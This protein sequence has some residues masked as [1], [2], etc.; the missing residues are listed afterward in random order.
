MIPPVDPQSS[1]QLLAVH[2][3][4][5]SLASLPG[6]VDALERGWSPDNIRGKAAADEHLDKIRCNASGFVEGLYDPEGRGAAIKIPDGSIVPR[7]PGY[8]RWVWDGEF[9]GSIGIRWQPGTAELPPHVLGHIG[10]AIVPWKENRGLATKAL[11][12]LL[13]EARPLGL[14]YVDLTTTPDNLASQRVIVAN[15]GQLMERFEKPA[16]YGGGATLRYRITL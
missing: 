11:S 10:Y 1:A 16:A 9:C 2:L 5:P 12:L 3:V 4:K 14:P 6:Y 13:V 8:V 7:I 15:G